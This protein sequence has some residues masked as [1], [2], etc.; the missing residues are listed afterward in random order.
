MLTSQLFAGDPIL[1]AVAADQDR[2]SRT[3]N[4]KGE[5]VR[6]VQQVLL[7]RNPGALPQFGA[8]GELRQ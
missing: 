6:K 2:I 3:Q 7:L 8:D 5:H 4:R 1:E